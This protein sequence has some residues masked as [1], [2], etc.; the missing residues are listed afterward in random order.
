MKYS[1]GNPFINIPIT[2][3]GNMPR[4]DKL[5]FGWKRNDKQDKSNT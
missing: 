3:T 1:P 2:F 4:L 5:T